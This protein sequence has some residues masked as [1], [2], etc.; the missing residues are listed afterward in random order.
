M[1]T[2]KVERNR[3]Q[4]VHSN[5]RRCFVIAQLKQWWT[6]VNDHPCAAFRW[7]YVPWCVMAA[8]C[9]SA[10]T[11]GFAVNCVLGVT[12]STTFLSIGGVEYLI[13]VIFVLLLIILPIPAP[14]YSPEDIGINDTG[15]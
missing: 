10:G 14:P 2:Y 11:V 3:L 15:L 8:L 5:Q 7:R 12:I 1:V 4:I 9:L 6:R 13:S